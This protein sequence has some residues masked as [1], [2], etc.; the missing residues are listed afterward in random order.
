[1][2][3][4]KTEEPKPLLKFD[5]KV[6][7]EY[8]EGVSQFTYQTTTETAEKAISTLFTEMGGE[9]VVCFGGGGRSVVF[10]RSKLVYI[11]ALF[12]D[13]VEEEK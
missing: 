11:E 8:G 1:M 4:R 6:I 2:F 13:V 10:P 9:K 7:C 5:M 12:V 3:K